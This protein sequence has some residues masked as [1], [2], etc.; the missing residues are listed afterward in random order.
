MIN[1]RENPPNLLFV[2][3]FLF[4]FAIFNLI[5]ILILEGIRKIDSVYRPIILLCTSL[6]V[7]I[8][9]LLRKWLE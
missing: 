5:L 8:G 3:G 6:I 4:S 7:I 9:L 2:A 1:K